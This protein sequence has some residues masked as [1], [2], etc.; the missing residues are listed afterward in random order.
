[1]TPCLSE[2]R[3]TSYS[4]AIDRILIC[5]SMSQEHEHSYP[6]HREEVWSKETV[7]LC[8]SLAIEKGTAHS[9]LISSSI[10]C[11]V[12]FKNTKVIVG[13]SFQS[14]WVTASLTTTAVRR[15]RN[16]VFWSSTMVVS[17]MDNSLPHEI[18]C[19]RFLLPHSDRAA[20][21]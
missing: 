21:Q 18:R 15:R 13:L 6:K 17:G 2:S 4:L 1:M 5:D 20:R 9:C 3:P 14:W 16:W 7:S 10:A 12:R 11:I 8:W 19:T